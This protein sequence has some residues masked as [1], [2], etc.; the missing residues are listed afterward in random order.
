MLTPG[1]LHLGKD[2]PASLL[3]LREREGEG[4]GDYQL[5]FDVLVVNKNLGE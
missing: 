1:G 4:E 5:L 2:G 3:C